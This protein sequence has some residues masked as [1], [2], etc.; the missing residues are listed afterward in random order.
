MA[1]KEAK[2]K[3]KIASKLKKAQTHIFPVSQSFVHLKLLA[4][5]KNGTGKTHMGATAPKPLIVDCNERGT[6]AARAIKD[7]QVFQVETWTDV[8]LAFWFLHSGKHDRQS[9][10]ID[11]ATLLQ[12]LCM[13]FV[14]SDEASRD[15]TKDPQ[16]PSKREWGKVG[17]LMR[18]V[19]MNFRN[20]PMHVIFTAQERMG[21]SEEDEEAPEIYPEVS[22]SARST[23]TAQVN[24]IGRTVVKEVV[25]KRG[26]KKI[27]TPDFRLV[28]GPSERFVT[29]VNIQNHGLPG[30]IRDP[31]ITRIIKRIRDGGK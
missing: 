14:L 4:Y 3:V 13:K 25:E 2:K 15:P 9:V 31:N 17:E 29:K 28:L 20:L 8:D 12:Q 23:L 10:V 19:I 27:R 6:L 22:P 11:S 26:K 21:F 1:T 18:T 5:G 7:V 16:M 24:V 30:I